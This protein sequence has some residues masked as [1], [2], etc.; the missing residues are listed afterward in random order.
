M[1]HSPT[2]PPARSVAR[3][4]FLLAAATLVVAGNVRPAQAQ[5]GT[6]PLP[7]DQLYPADRLFPEA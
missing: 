4:T 2:G 3:R 7:S 5:P 6:A 1:S